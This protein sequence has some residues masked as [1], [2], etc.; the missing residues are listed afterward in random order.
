MEDGEALNADWRDICTSTE[1]LCIN[2]H[3]RFVGF[4]KITFGWISSQAQVI[5]NALCPRCAM[6]WLDRLFLFACW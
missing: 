2:A 5:A 6:D 3:G 4:Q 1:V